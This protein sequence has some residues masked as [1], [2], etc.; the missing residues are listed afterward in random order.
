MVQLVHFLSSTAGVGTF[1]LEFGVLSRLT[2]NPVYEEAAVK[3]LMALWDHRS[4]LGLLG[5]HINVE[6]GQW[7]ATDAGIGA[8]VDSYYEY[9]VKG[10]ALLSR[11]ELMAM[12]FQHLESIERFMRKDDW[13]TFK[14]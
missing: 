8:A 2:Q 9:L 6:S 10:S 13:Y 7:V 12:F 1:I 4:S 14:P 5:N 3:A 11:P